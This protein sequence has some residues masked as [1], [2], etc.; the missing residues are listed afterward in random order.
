MPRRT[1]NWYHFQVES[2]GAMK[3]KQ[4]SQVK[5]HTGLCVALFM[6][7]LDSLIPLAVIQQAL[8]LYLMWHTLRWA[9]GVGP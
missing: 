6:P 4:M 2:L 1:V 8:T 5:N 3:A 9:M 7:V